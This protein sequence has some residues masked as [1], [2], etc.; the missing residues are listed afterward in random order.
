MQLRSATRK[1][2]A[3]QEKILRS[4]PQGA[5][6]HDSM[7]GTRLDA[8]FD[9][10]VVPASEGAEKQA[11]EGASPVRTIGAEESLVVPVVDAQQ[12]TRSGRVRKPPERLIMEHGVKRY[13]STN[14][15]VVQMRLIE[16]MLID[17]VSNYVDGIHPLSFVAKK[18]D[19]DTPNYQMAMASPDQ[20]GYIEAMKVEITALE[21]QNTWEL[22]ERKMLPKGANVLP[23]T[24]AFKRKRYPDGLIW[25]LKA[26]FCVR[27][28][29]QIEG[30]DYFDTY[31]P[32][33][34]WLTVRLMFTLSLVLNLATKQVDYANAFV[35]ADLKEDVYVE[36]PKDFKQANDDRDFVLKLNK[37]LYGLKQAPLVWFERLRDGLLVRG[38][39]QSIIEPCLFIHEESGLICLVYVDDCLFFAKESKDI[40]DMIDS[41]STEFK[42]EP[43]EDVTAFLGIQFQK[44]TSGTLELI[45]PHLIN[46]IIETVF[47][48]DECHAKATPTSGTPLHADVDGESCIE[49]WDY[50]SVVGMLMYL[51]NNSRPDIAFAVHQCARFSFHPKRSH[52]EAIKRIV[53]YLKGTKENGLFFTP[54][55]KFALDCYVDA[56][57]AG[58]WRYEDDQ[59]PVS[60]KSRTGYMLVF[61]GCPLLWVSKLQMEIALS[62]TEAEYIALS[63]SMRDLL[64]TKELIVELLPQ[65]GIKLENVTTYSTVFEDNQGAIA[66]ANA[67]KLTPRTKHIGIKYH[68]FREHVRIGN[69]RIQ[70][71]ETGKQIADVLTKGLTAMK[72]QCLRKM[73]MGW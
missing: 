49:Q 29:K 50:A 37:S 16:D 67:P 38:F 40:D 55:K 71:V 68:F 25:K 2:Q 73:L 21:K 1:A 17:P 61:A 18:Y 33:V 64:P 51:S 22:C 19:E 43:E 46:R 23:S 31:A 36:C 52:E 45:Q 58:L 13:E 69:I 12:Q 10:E 14:S 8:E 72:F 7:G 11:R 53:R 27:G 35:Q 44:H 62:T 4:S 5:L 9:Q 30:V 26:R 15:F 41:L 60:V 66:L 3:S 57:F 39:R 48:K 20:E 24:W 32:V 6:H 70:Y 42:L 34:S 54:N 59:D 56:D 63:Q 28:D 47:G 65:F